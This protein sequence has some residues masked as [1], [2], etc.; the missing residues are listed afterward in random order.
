MFRNA[1]T[2][3]GNLKAYTF[4]SKAGVYRPLFYEVPN[5]VLTSCTVPITRIAPGLLIAAVI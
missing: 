3:P 2:G 4:K 1:R 5:W